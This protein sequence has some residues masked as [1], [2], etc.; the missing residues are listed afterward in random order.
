MLS[1]YDFRLLDRTFFEGFS[2]ADQEVGE[3]V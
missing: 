2:R 1:A 3:K